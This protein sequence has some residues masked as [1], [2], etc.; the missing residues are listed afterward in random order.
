MQSASTLFACC[1]LLLTLH[2]QNPNTDL[3]QGLFDFG[4]SSSDGLP[5]PRVDLSLERVEKVNAGAYTKDS[6]LWFS[7]GL[8]YSNRLATHLT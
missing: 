1:P 6:L 7:C 3:S 5:D 4:G 2:P 8:L